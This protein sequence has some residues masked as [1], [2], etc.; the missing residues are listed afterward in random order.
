[1]CEVRYQANQPGP[2]LAERSFSVAVPERQ[3]HL[4][5]S[6]GMPYFANKRFFL[7][8]AHADIHASP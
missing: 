8:S 7:R 6:V 4:F 2:E 5:W 3:M 1:M